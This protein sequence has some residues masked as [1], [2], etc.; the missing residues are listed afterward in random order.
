MRTRFQKKRI[1]TLFQMQHLPSSKYMSLLSEALPQV[2]SLHYWLSF[3]SPGA[4]M[5]SI[6]IRTSLPVNV[7]KIHNEHIVQFRPHKHLQLQPYHDQN[8]LEKSILSNIYIKH[9]YSHCQMNSITYPSDVMLYSLNIC[10][11]LIFFTWLL[12]ATCSPVFF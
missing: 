1:S 2:C 9:P 11:I 3:L 4:I 5:S 12:F 6:L 8:Q 10:I 7:V